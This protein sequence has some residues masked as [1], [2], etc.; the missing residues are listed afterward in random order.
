MILNTIYNFLIENNLNPLTIP[1]I[2]ELGSY[3]GGYA[4][5]KSISLAGGLKNVRKD[6]IP[7]VTEVIKTL[8]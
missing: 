2:N 3:K 5:V 4:L 8:D 1:T 6:Y 7:W